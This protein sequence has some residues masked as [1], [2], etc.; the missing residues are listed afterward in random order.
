MWRSRSWDH[1]QSRWI[2]ASNSLSYLILLRSWCRQ[3][4]PIETQCICRRM[5]KHL[6]RAVLHA[7]ASCA[8]LELT[9]RMETNSPQREDRL[10]ERK[11]RRNTSKRSVSVLC[12]CW[13]HYC[14]VH[15]SKQQCS[16]NDIEVA[17][18]GSCTFDLKLRIIGYV[19]GWKGREGSSLSTLRHD[20]YGRV[21]S[22]KSTISVFQKNLAILLC[23]TMLQ[24]R[25]ATSSKRMSTEAEWDRKS[26]RHSHSSRQLRHSTLHVIRTRA[27]RQ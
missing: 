8:S 14:R 6:G 1:S 2:D 25:R 9:V 7:L 21:G 12:S 19:P 20:A 11:L 5:A 15:S 3:W 10:P 18:R 24:R 4:P 26:H 17:N 13:P 22:S 27:G 23:Q 16:V